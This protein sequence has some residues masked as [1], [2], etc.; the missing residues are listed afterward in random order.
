MKICYNF[1]VAEC[2]GVVVCDDFIL[3]NISNISNSIVNKT[4]FFSNELSS[5]A[6][7]YCFR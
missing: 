4:L 5:K 7:N 2:L 3:Y 6:Y 1:C